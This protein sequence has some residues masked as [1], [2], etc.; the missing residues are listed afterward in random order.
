MAS[1]PGCGEKS[2]GWFK[3][4]G[5]CQR[6]EDLSTNLKA[7]DLITSVPT[8]DEAVAQVAAQ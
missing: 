2:S 4:C 1:C 5:A 8:A 7:K 6:A 3:L